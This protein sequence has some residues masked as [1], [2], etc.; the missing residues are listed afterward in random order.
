[1]ESFSCEPCGSNYKKCLSEDVIFACDSCE[2]TTNLKA[3]LKLH[4]SRHSIQ[5]PTVV[6]ECDVCEAT[7]KMKKHLK[8]HKETH[9]P[10]EAPIG[11]PSSKGFSCSSC[12][13]GYSTKSNLQKHINTIHL[14]PKVQ[15]VE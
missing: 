2:Y 10:K 6:H 8:K 3:N 14:N 15:K 12:N 4:R 13:K 9:A 7:F 5:K 1:M 11:V